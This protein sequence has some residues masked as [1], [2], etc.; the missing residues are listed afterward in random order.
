MRYLSEIERKSALELAY[1]AISWAVSHRILPK[2]IPGAGAF[3]E[4]RGVFV[5]LYL[6]EKLQG[7]I[8]VVEARE[9]LGDGIVRCAISAALGDPRFCPLQLDQPPRLQIEIS[10]LAPEADLAGICARGA[11]RSLNLA[12]R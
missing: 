5:T 6:E 11:P 12:P 1:D 9:S 3:A 8:G 7:C 10:F 2:P 4:P